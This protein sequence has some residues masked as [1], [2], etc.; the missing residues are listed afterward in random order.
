VNRSKRARS[1]AQIL[2]AVDFESL[3]SPASSQLSPAPGAD[4]RRGAGG[5]DPAGPRGCRAVR[6]CAVPAFDE[7]ASYA[8]AGGDGRWRLRPRA[9]DARR[10]VALL[11]VAKPALVV[12]PALIARS[13]QPGLELILDRPLNDQSGAEPR[14]LRE[15]LSGVL[16]DPDGK[17]PI[18]LFLYLRRRRYGASH[19]VGLPS[20]SCRTLGNLRRAL[21]GP[22]AIYSSWGTRPRDG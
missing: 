17:Q 18:D 3:P 19:G 20:W 1:S 12:G 22:S 2:D 13:T 15:R 11:V 21:D 9:L 14:Q 7:A 5:R 4:R 16:A 6:V 8:A 10:R